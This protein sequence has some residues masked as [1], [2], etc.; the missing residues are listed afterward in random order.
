MCS[1]ISEV[2]CL[3]PG[4]ALGH[5]VWGTLLIFTSL[6]FSLVASLL[7]VETSEGS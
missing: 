5:C 7:K 6:L 3:G 1:E 2:S 4:L